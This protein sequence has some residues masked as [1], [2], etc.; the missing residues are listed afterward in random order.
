[1]ATIDEE[2]NQLERDIRT[3]KIEY[4]QFFG[5]G[6]K[7]PPA[8]TQWRVDTMVRRYNERAGELSYGQRFRFNNLAQTYAKY[9]RHVAQE[10][11]AERDRDRAASFRRGR[12]SDRG[13]T[14]AHGGG[15]GRGCI[16]SSGVERQ[17]RTERRGRSRLP[18]RLAIRSKK[19]ERCRSS[20]TS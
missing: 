12:E 5:G 10:N 17:T 3:L 2:L 4:E 20:T 1:M 11:G 19:T 16:R 6:R 7:R 8:D 15:M 9:Q 14:R 13:G 18:L